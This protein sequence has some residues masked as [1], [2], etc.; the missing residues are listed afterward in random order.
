MFTLCPPAGNTMPVTRAFTAHQVGI[1][2]TSA[3]QQV[4]IY[5]ATNAQ[6]LGPVL[7]NTIMTINQMILTY[8]KRDFVKKKYN[9]DTSMR[10]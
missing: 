3:G 1:H 5:R 9:H 10:L 7:G 8:L 6:T 4:P 2:R